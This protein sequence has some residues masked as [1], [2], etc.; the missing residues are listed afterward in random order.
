ME[1]KIYVS[2]TE[3]GKQLL[4]LIQEWVDENIDNICYKINANNVKLNSK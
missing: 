4:Q 3:D 1:N 2:Y